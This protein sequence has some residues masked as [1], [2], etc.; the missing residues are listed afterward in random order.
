MDG[1]IGRIG[2]VYDY[3]HRAYARAPAPTPKCHGKPS[4]PSEGAEIL[5]FPL[6]G[7]FRHPSEPEASRLDIVIVVR[8][9]LLIAVTV[10]DHATM[11]IDKV[12]GRFDQL[13]VEPLDAV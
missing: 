8:P 1:R 5:A 4:D 2:S 11:L 7:T 10:I 9:P 6:P 12:G 13:E 3:I